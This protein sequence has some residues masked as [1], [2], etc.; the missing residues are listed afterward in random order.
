MLSL[1][2]VVSVAND[3]CLFPHDRYIG[4]LMLLLLSRF[5]CMRPSFL[6]WSSLSCTGLLVY[7]RCR[8][9]WVLNLCRPSVPPLPA[10]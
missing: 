1:Q 8:W 10:S 7:P 9:S 2:G 6:A 5:F 3:G 4:P